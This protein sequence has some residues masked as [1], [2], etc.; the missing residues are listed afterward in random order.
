MGFGRGDFDGG[1]DFD[2]LELPKSVDYP[3]GYFING[4]GN[5]ATI[6]RRTD[7]ITMNTNNF[8]TLVAGPNGL[9]YDLTQPVGFTVYI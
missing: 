7:G 6:Q 1:A 4:N 9:S 3:I 5:S 2:I 8:E